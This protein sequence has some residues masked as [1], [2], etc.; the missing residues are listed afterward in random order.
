MT[1]A[2]AIDALWLVRSPLLFV[3]R[4]AFEAGLEGWD[5]A[6]IVL[7]GQEIGVAMRKGPEYHFALVGRQVRI[8]RRLVEEQFAPQ[9]EAYGH[10]ITRT[11]KHETRQRRFNEAFGFV[12][13][14][15][16]ALDIHYRLER[17]TCPQ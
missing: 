15:E 1:R 9:L 4:E 16:D 14:G 13:T 10:V 8:P 11:P 17:K 3:S 5:L 6:P 2:Q 12:R 7:D